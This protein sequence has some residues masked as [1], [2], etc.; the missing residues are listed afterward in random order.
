MTTTVATTAADAADSGDGV[1]ERVQQLKPLLR[2]E[3][4]ENDRIQR[5]PERSLAALKEAGVWKM[6]TPKYYGG[7]ETPFP[8]VFETLRTIVSACPSIG[9]ATTLTSINWLVARCCDELQDE[10][11][12]DNPNAL[13]P[14]VFGSFGARAKRVSGGIE[15]VGGGRWGFNSGCPDGDWDLLGAVVEEPDGSETRLWIAVPISD[16]ELVNDWDVTA[17][18]G[19]ASW[20]ATC[21]DIFVPD[22]RILSNRNDLFGGDSANESKRQANNPYYG[23]PPYMVFSNFLALIPSGVADGALEVFVEQLP[24]RKITHTDYLKASEAPIVH[25]QV[26]E[27][28]MKASA[29]DALRERLVGLC[30]NWKPGDPELPAQTRRE[31]LVG[32]SVYCYQLAREAVDLLYLASGPRVIREDNPIQRFQRDIQAFAQHVLLHPDT[33]FENI[34]RVRCGL[35]PF[36]GAART[37][38]RPAPTGSS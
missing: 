5:I 37:A 20:T 4:L 17:A 33:Q 11:F 7:Y 27:A 3:A 32:G 14:S 6:M 18:R 36:S 8:T 28:T 22:H 9:W 1:L 16:L 35:P 30:T 31:Q 26:G 34:G 23:P 29:I 38:G 2:A 12:G 24:G 21:G 13:I 25:L 10:V 19:T 15:I